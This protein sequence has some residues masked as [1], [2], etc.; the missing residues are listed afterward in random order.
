MGPRWKLKP[1]RG[2]FHSFRM[3]RTAGVF[4]AY[5][6]DELIL[7]GSGSMA[8]PGRVTLLFGGD[9]AL[10]VDLLVDRVSVV[11]EPA[12]VLALAAGIGSLLLS[13]RRRTR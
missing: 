12:S 7:R 11:P 1:P 5:L 8:V 3:T 10:P 2:G 13:R 6:N 9:R 4:S